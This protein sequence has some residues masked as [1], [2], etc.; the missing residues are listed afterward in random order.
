[1][2]HIVYDLVILA[3]LILFALWGL[4]RGLILSL[5][6][7]LAVLVAIVGAILVSNLLGPTVAGWLQPTLQ[8]VVSSAVEA[9]LP[10]SVT[11]AELPQDEL[12]TL[13][14]EAE[15]P[16]G[17]DAFLDDALENTSTFSAGTLIDVLSASL[18]EKLASAAAYICLF[19]LTFLLIL[20]LWYCLMHT[21]NLVARFPGL[22][23]L[24]KTGGL[25]FG[26]FR[27]AVYLLICAW[28]IRWLWSDLI[29]AELVEQS[30]L[31]RFFMTFESLHG[32]GK[33]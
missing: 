22:H 31:L 16:L 30:L 33:L 1:M 15:L 26:L 18:A 20:V 7:L 9:A 17:L 27:G 10:E 29:P 14:E 32:L 5:F 2:N 4:H 28:V 8:P 13:L 3:I 25:V 21:L 23:A 6:S 12:L 24:N 11:Q 19:L